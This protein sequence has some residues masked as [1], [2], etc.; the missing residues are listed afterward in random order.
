MLVR[1]PLEGLTHI[2]PL[3]IYSILA[4]Y[5]ELLSMN[6]ILQKSKLILFGHGTK[7]LVPGSHRAKRLIIL[8]P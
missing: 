3:L 6:R 4:F 5:I 8:C 2:Y 7:V 1:L